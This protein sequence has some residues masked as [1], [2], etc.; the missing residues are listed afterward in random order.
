MI[1]R[2]SLGELA[3]LRDGR[4]RRESSWDRTGGNAD[5]II[6]RPG[7]RATLCNVS[8]AGIVRH[9]WCTMAAR[10]NPY[11]ARTTVL[12]MYWDGATTPCVEA[13]VGDFFGIGHSIIKD[14]WSLPLSMSP[15]DG[16]GFNCFFPM[17][18][19]TRAL[20]EVENESED[21][22]I[23]YYYVDYEELERLDEDLARFHAQWRRENPTTGWGEG[24]YDDDLAKGRVGELRRQVWTTPNLD[25][26]ENYVILEAEGRGHYVGCNLNVDCF[27]R[28]KNDWYGE[29][30]DM[31]FI[32]GEVWPPSLHGTGT[33]DYFNTAFSPRT[34]FCTPY[35]GVTVYSGTDDWPYKGKNSLYRFH[36]EDPVMFDKSIRVTIEHGHANSL[37]NDYSSTAYWYQVEPHAPFPP[38]PAAAERLPR[39]DVP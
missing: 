33:E 27:S 28:Q 22:M 10:S 29:G 13:P 6:L 17:P 16:R 37:S 12:R 35:H 19:A 3:R 5:F 30:D 25:G 14:F 38:L 1:G 32:D 18:F 20:I 34:E 2:N 24:R 15:Q 26:K 9:I 31:I 11:Y 36:L 7:E 8:G 39:P 4:R 23:F 21:G